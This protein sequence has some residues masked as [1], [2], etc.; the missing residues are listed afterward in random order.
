MNRKIF[1]YFFVAALVAVTFVR[2]DMKKDSVHG[3]SKKVRLYV[4]EKGTYKIMDRVIRSDKEWKRSLTSE[5]F[6]ITRK[7]G[8]ERPFSGEYDKFYEKGIYTCKCCDNDLFDSATKFDSGTGWPSYTA[9]IA[10]ENVRLEEDRSLFMIRTEVLCARCDAHLGH[11][12]QDGPPPGGLRFCINA[13][14]LKKLE[15]ADQAQI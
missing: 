6:K 13:L 9:P 1:P 15:S 2:C 8:T 4:A 5:E 11:V 14:A 12:F 3:E 10:P 7:K